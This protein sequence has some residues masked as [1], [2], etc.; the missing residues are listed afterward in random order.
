MG[1]LLSQYP[2]AIAQAILRM[3]ANSGRIAV[4]NAVDQVIESKIFKD[5]GL[6]S[7]FWYGKYEKS[8]C[9]GVTACEGGQCWITKDPAD[10]YLVKK[11]PTK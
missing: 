8:N 5:N 11:I 2:E 9:L 10:P 4:G 3:K 1:E 6:A 7:S